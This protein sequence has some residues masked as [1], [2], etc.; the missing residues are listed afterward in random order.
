MQIAI[1]FIYN[2]CQLRNNIYLRSSFVIF[3]GC[4]LP[5]IATQW[6]KIFTQ[7]SSAKGD[8]GVTRKKTQKM[9]SFPFSLQHVSMTKIEILFFLFHGKKLIK[10]TSSR[11]PLY[12]SHFF[13]C[14][15]A[16][17][18]KA[19]EYIY[20]FH[21]HVRRSSQISQKRWLCALRHQWIRYTQGKL[22]FYEFFRFLL[23]LN[24]FECCCDSTYNWNIISLVQ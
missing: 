11:Y 15:G 19:L 3:F 22:N 1:L 8:M 20:Y 21:T 16:V 5:Q 18:E 14:T 17:M 13:L 7:V 6:W 4:H 10:K 9:P 24:E 23:F 12:R 2:H